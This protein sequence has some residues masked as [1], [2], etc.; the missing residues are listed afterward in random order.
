LNRRKFL[1]YLAIAAAAG[2]LGAVGLDYY[3]T[4]DSRTVNTSTSFSSSTTNAFSNYPPVY[5]EFLNWLGSVAKPYA[6]EPVNIALEDEA[7]PRAIQKRDVDFFTASQINSQYNIQP[8]QLLLQQ[9]SLMVNTKSSSYDVFEVDHQDVSFFKDSI[10]SP[11]QLAEKYPDLTYEPFKSID[12]QQLPWSV[13]AT[14]PPTV[15]GDSPASQATPTS[16]SSDQIVFIPLDLPIMVQIYRDDIYKSRGLSAAANW[17]Q[18]LSNAKALDQS[19]SIRFGTS[20]GAGPTVSAVYEFAN[21][22]ASFG[23]QLWEFDGTQLTSGLSSSQALSALENFA[24]LVP[25]SDPAS[26]TYDWSQVATDISRGYA[27]AGLD[28]YD[29]SYLLESPSTSFVAGEVGFAQNP[30]GPMGSFSTYGGGGI[31]VS[32]YSKHPEAAWLWLQWATAYGTQL[33]MV[34]D[35]FH[36]LPTRTAV[37]QDPSIQNSLNGSDYQALQVASQIW[38]TNDVFALTPFPKWWN[39]LNIIDFHLSQVFANLETPESSLQT[40]VQ[41]IEKLGTLIF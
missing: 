15:I 26:Y 18:Y 21:H 25:Y 2:T 12:F 6:G 32:A 13:L 1:E 9:I 7:T 29:Y 38:K 19:T 5:S 28:W 27:S 8:Y 30:S 34:T 10:L 17:S 3:A 41:Q 33:M 31:G 37:L 35:T 39:A 40:M 4:R 20:S 24:S 14:Y 16:S 36:V 11:T 23:G 22:L